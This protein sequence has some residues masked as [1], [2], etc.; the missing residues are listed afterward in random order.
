MT[1]H[2][3]LITFLEHE[4][5]FLRHRIHRIEHEGWRFGVT[6]AD[7]DT[8]DITRAELA[9]AKEKLGE[10]VEHVRELRFAG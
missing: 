2:D 8:D 9:A 7:G 5:E 6:T 3:K 4:A 1:R 10:I